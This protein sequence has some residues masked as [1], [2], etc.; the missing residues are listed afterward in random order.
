MNQSVLTLA[1]G[2]QP[3]AQ[4]LGFDAAAVVVDNLT[5][6]Y[7]RLTDVG[8]D[9]PPF[10]YGAVVALPPGLRR[11][12]AS[13]VATVP[14]VAGPPVPAAKA[15]L[16]WTDQVLP[17]S[18]GHLL[19][20]S[21]YQQSQ[22]L[23]HITVLANGS[24]TVTVS[25]PAG[26][27]SIGWQVDGLAGDGQGPDAVS[28]NGQQSGVLYNA[29][30]FP[31]SGQELFAVPASPV[32]TS[33]TVFVGARV[34]AACAIY[35]IAW[36]QA[37]AAPL[38]TTVAA[39]TGAQL[40]AVSEQLASPAPWQAA[41]KNVSFSGVVGAGGTAAVLGAAG[42][43][44]A[45]Y[46]HASDLVI[47]AGPGGAG[48]VILFDTIGGAGFAAWA[49]TVGEHATRQGNGFRLTDNAGVSFFNNS[50][51]AVTIA[52]TLKYAGPAT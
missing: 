8:V 48:E 9:L 47:K 51:G 26:T 14:A 36:A 7:V 3:L 45:Y 32:D 10:V 2:G 27:Q 40:L 5:S 23:Q 11:A 33:L 38:P 24:S 16:T 35:V 17:T 43:G 34:A 41:T 44:L 12:T 4:A 22:V 25:L 29:W 42:A 15:T 50:A 13:L 30:A 19:Q 20:Q 37:P 39:D 1:P 49:G 6:S 18:A 28:F 21:S 46:V 31:F 52:G